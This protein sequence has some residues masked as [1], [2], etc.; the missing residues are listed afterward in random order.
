MYALFVKYVREVSSG[1]RD[2]II[3]SNVLV[4][5]TGAS[6]E[7]QHPSIEFALCEGSSNAHVNIPSN[8]SFNIKIVLL[9]DNGAINFFNVLWIV[10][11]RLNSENALHIHFTCCCKLWL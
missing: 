10:I 5:V 11:V 8:N 1:R 9:V 4:F 7:L 3:V 6:E 2:G